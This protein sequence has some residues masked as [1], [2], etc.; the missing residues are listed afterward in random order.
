MSRDKKKTHAYGV[1][2]FERQGQEDE[3]II[4]Q[5]KVQEK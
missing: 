2:G 4:G 3:W 1:E 5:E